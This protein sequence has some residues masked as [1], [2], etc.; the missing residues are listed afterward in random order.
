ML[1]LEFMVPPFPLLSAI[2]HT[3]WQS[4]IVHY[5]RRFTVYDM[6]ICT[7]GTLHME[8]DGVRY[9]LKEGM[10]LVLEQGK[11]HRGYRPSESETEVYWI[12][13][14]YPSS[15]QPKLVDKS[16]WQQPLLEHTDQDIDPHPG[17]IDIPK[18]APVDLRAV[19]PLLSEMLK[20]YSML[21]PARSYELQVRFGQ[22]LLELQH[23]MRQKSPQARSYLLGEEVASYLEEHLEV[24]F[25]SK[26]MEKEMNYHFDY[27]ARCLKQYTGMSPLQYRHHMQVNRAKQL[28]THTDWP[29]IKIGEHCGFQDNNYFSRLF[30]RQTSFTPGEYRRQYQ[31]FR[32]K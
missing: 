25:D 12:H 16:S 18:F 7:Q 10:V 1:V 15:S 9:D 21:T 32:V 27:L 2:G 20:L 14:Q 3:Q 28:L 22:L 24:P 26:Q 19:V 11:L 6:I 31:V 13:F 29:L 8:E 4:G 5:E 17:M 23:T 30:K